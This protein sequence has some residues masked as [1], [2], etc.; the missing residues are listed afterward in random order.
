VPGI[1]FTESY[2][3]VI[4]DSSYRIILIGMMLLNLKAKIIEV[5]TAFL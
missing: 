3:P 1:D 4:N 2:A 5:E